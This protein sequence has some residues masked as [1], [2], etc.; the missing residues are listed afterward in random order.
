MTATTITL[1]LAKAEKQA[2][3]DYAKTFGMTVSEFVRT[4]ALSLIEDELVLRVWEGVKREFDDTPQTLPAS[5]AA[6]KHL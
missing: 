6:A 2:L 3:V 5:G 1:R 4:A